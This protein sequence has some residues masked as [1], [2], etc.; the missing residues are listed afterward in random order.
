MPL[1]LLLFFVV[2][3]VACWSHCT[4]VKEKKKKP[5][6]LVSDVSCPPDH[7]FAH[8]GRQRTTGTKEKQDRNEMR[9]TPEWSCCRFPFTVS[10][11]LQPGRGGRFTVGTALQSVEAVAI[12]QLASGNFFDVR[13][14]S[15]GFREPV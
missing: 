1:L 2:I 13:S 6:S 4:F 8:S 5:S 11:K 10:G 7:A 15:S 12:L 14:Y 9:R 3:V